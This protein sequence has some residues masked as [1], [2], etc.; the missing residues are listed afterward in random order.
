MRLMTKT[1]KLWL[2]YKEITSQIDHCI[3]IGRNYDGLEI[4]A[5]QALKD[6]WD[7]IES[8]RIQGETM[9]LTEQ[10]QAAEKAVRD[11]YVDMY[12]VDNET[13][14]QAYKHALQE[15]IRI[16]DLLNGEN[17]DG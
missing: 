11:A 15:A 7:A 4:A 16:K 2:I 17:N 5:N 9:T 13:N 3:A 8:V 10:Y 6:Y 12:Y 14:F 1:R